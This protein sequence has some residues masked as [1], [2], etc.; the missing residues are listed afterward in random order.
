MAQSSGSAELADA[1]FPLAVGAVSAML[2]ALLLQ[3]VWPGRRY[4]LLLRI[5]SADAE[6]LSSS[7]AK[8]IADIKQAIET[9]FIARAQHDDRK[10][11][12]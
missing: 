8:F 10:Q 6:A 7:Q 11:T 4:K 12:A 3:L 9:A 5:H 1:N 2:A